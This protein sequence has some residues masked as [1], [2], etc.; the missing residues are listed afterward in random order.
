MQCVNVKRIPYIVYRIPLSFQC[1]FSHRY[2]C[3]PSIFE[4]GYYYILCRAYK[5]VKRC[6]ALNFFPKNRN[7]TKRKSEFSLFA[8][9]SMWLVPSSRLYIL[10]TAE[11]VSRARSSF[12]LLLIKRNVD[13]PF[14]CVS[15]F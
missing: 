14:S 1:I 11:T 7:R 13:F 8:I 4:F 10:L 2:H 15:G 5:R 9:E 3:Q 12:S 6:T